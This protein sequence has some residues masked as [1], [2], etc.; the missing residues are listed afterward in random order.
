M[1]FGIVGTSIWQQNMPLLERLTVDRET[2]AAEIARLKLLLGVDE[3]VY[4]ATCN[5]VEFIYAT[6]SKIAPG[7]LLHRLIDHFF[8]DQREICFFPNDFYHF[9]GREAILHLFR[10]ASSLE[11]L[12]VGETQI[13]GQLKQAHQ[14]ALDCGVA[15]TVTSG[16]ITEALQVAK[17]VK[18]ETDLGI[19]ALSMASLAA[20]ELSVRLERAADPV[21][22]LVG[23]G[24]MTSKMAKYILENKV[25]HLL[26][27]NRTVSKADALAAE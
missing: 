4:L 19:G 6:S 7:K 24:P 1:K 21:I 13:T 8:R 18:R 3:L 10:T 25:G 16:L 26:F 5:R 27:V 23:A 15:G 17:R 9:T 11:S 14:D 12:V 2:R 20:T 22:A